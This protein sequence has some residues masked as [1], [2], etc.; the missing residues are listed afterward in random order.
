MASCTLC[1]LTFGLCHMSLYT[2]SSIP[3]PGRVKLPHACL[4]PYAACKAGCHSRFGYKQTSILVVAEWSQT[5]W[6][7]SRSSKDASSR[8][9]RVQGSKA[10]LATQ[11]LVDTV[12]RGITTS[13]QGQQLLRRE[14]RRK[15]TKVA[16]QEAS[17]EGELSAG[18]AL[19]GAQV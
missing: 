5:A 11:E 3:V 9:Y 2:V 1:Q 19:N 12:E 8:A 4:E 16:E 18:H 7:S 17:N 15:P 13:Q 14:C 6:R 10:V